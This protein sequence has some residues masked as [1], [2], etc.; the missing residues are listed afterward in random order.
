V[1]SLPKKLICDEKKL[2]KKF[3]WNFLVSRCSRE[4]A[5]STLLESCYTW[6]SHVLLNKSR[7]ICASNFTH[8]RGMPHIWTSRVTYERVKSRM[9]ESCHVWTSHATHEWVMSITLRTVARLKWNILRVMSRISESCNTC[10]SHVTYE[11]VMS[12]WISHVTYAQVM[13]NTHEACQTYEH[14]MSRMNE[15]CLTLVSHVI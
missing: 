2:K 13:S 9:S 1:S 6:V 7:R 11:W 8:A 10:T 4:I 15:S 14:V 3:S 5:K 12:H